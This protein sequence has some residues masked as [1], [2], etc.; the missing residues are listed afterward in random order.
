MCIRDRA[1][2]EYVTIWRLESTF[3]AG[4]PQL[5]QVYLYANSQRS[6]LLAVVVPEWGAVRER[7]RLEGKEPEPAAVKGLLRRCV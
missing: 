6:S 7:L 4:S 5:D 3:S 2:G 1:Q